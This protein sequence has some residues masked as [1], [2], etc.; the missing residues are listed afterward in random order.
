MYRI[1]GLPGLFLFLPAFLLVIIPLIYLFAFSFM[2]NRF[3]HFPVTGW[4]FIWYKTLFSDEQLINSVLFS[5]FLSSIIG[6]LATFFGF[7]SGYSFARSSSKHIFSLII[8]LTLPAV[9]PYLVYGLGF[10]ELSRFIGIERTGLSL[11]IAHISVFSP[12]SMTYFYFQIRETNMDFDN[13][14]RELGAKG[15]DVIKLHLGTLKKEVI[16]CMIIIFVLSWD[17]YIISWF[18][19]GFQ[20]TYAVQVRNMMESTFSPEVFAIGTVISIIFLFLVISAMRLSK[21]V[22]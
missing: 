20:K 13:S 6:I 18:L 21:T 17:E 3:L 15:V 14:A 8:I 2:E 16:A 11:V 7:L 12:L 22:K 5:I 4:S 10:L 19:T 1:R 9:I